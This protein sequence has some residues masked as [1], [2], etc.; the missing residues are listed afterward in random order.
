[1]NAD[2]SLWQSARNILDAE[3]N[4]NKLFDAMDGVTTSKIRLGHRVQRPRQK[5]W[6]MVT[7]GLEPVLR[8]KKEQQK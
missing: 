3:D 7:T 2:A 8:C 4:L 5:Q 1:M 6:G